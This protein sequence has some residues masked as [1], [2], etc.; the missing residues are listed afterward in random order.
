MPKF[1]YVVVSQGGNLFSEKWVLW[2][3][4]NLLGNLGGYF[5]QHI[6]IR[7]P[8]APLAALSGMTLAHKLHELFI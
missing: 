2:G 4:A 5:A 1:H 6:E 7:L 8:K 3:G